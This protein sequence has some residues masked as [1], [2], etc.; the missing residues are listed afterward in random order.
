MDGVYFTPFHI[1]HLQPIWLTIRYS[2]CILFVSQAVPAAN[3]YS[4]ALKCLHCHGQAFSSVTISQLQQQNIQEDLKLQ[5]QQ[6]EKLKNWDCFI[7]L[8][9][10]TVSKQKTM[11]N[12]HWSK[13]TMQKDLAVVTGFKKKNYYNFNEHHFMKDSARVD[14]HFSKWHYVCCCGMPSVPKSTGNTKAHKHSHWSIHQ[15]QSI[16]QNC[17]WSTLLFLSSL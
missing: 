11:H 7:H 15:A 3:W 12:G 4:D 17:L 1:F 6:C 8:Q 14:Q 9:D 5:Q 16:A 10:C 13:A 2:K